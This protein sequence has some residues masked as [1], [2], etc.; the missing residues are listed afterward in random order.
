[1]LSE[2]FSF[3]SGDGTT[4]FAY[5]WSPDTGTKVKG[6]VQIAHGMA[7]TA[8]RY[9]RFAKLLT[10]N[11]YIVYANDHR[12]HG[13]TAGSLEKVGYLAEKDGFDWLV[14]DMYQLTTII[15]KEHSDLPVFL[16]GH[17]MGSFAAQRYIM[18]FGRELRGVIL[19]G[20]N[21]RAV[22]LHRFGF[23][24]AGREVKKN[25]RKTK[26]Q[27]MNRLS[28]GN[29]NNAF[30]PNRTEFDWLSRDK[31]EVDKYIK[32]PY[33]GDVFSGGFFYDFMKGLKEIDK[34]KNV[35]FIPKNLPILIFSGDKDPVGGRGKGVKKLYNTY[36]K[37]GIQEVTL[38]LYPG[39]RHEMLNEINK[40]EV[41]RDVIEW[42]NLK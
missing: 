15:K 39:G 42:L 21:G 24:A 6:A 31:D 18:L 36:K 38:K 10:Q 4:V 20:S 25:G 17:S 1:M 23:L 30:K 37:A 16:F 33:C 9:E 13:K 14:K 40:E 29:F 27:K 7:E 28:F 2:N 12:G 41:M 34:A 8:L 19:S 5:K 11:G 35:A 32:D 22:L 3:Q 26:S